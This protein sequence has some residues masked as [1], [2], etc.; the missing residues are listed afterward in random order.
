MRKRIRRRLVLGPLFLA[1]LGWTYFATAA[2]SH[3]A[4]PLKPLLTEEGQ[5][6]VFDKGTFQS[7]ELSKRL[8]LQE[9]WPRGSEMEK[10]LERFGLAQ[11]NLGRTVP[12]PSRITSVTCTWWARTASVTL[13][14]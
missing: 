4:A 3:N 12:V 11:M 10:A 7:R 6:V 13:R 1:L 2:A 8:P 9:A 5:Q 14:T